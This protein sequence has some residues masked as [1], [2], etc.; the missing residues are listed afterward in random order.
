MHFSKFSF[1]IHLLKDVWAL[2]SFGHFLWITSI[3]NLLFGHSIFL[4]F[5]RKKENSSQMHRFSSKDLQ[6]KGWYISLTELKA[7][8]WSGFYIVPIAIIHFYSRLSHAE[9]QSNHMK[10][11]RNLSLVIWQEVGSAHL[12]LSHVTGIHRSKRNWRL[13]IFIS[14]KCLIHTKED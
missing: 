6:K 3:F 13:T 10:G 12:F 11:Y 1:L 8:A 7:L 14:F 4:P 9:P 5:S 2:Y